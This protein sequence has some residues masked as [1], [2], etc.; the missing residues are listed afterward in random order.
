MRAILAHAGAVDPRLALVLALGAELRI[1]QVRRARRQDLSLEAGTFVVHGRGKK[2]GETIDLT[3]G[4]LVVV[5]EALATG[6][7]RDVEAA[8]QA[9]ALDDYRLFPQGQMPGGRSGA[10]VATVARHADAQPLDERTLIVWFREAEALAGVESQRGR[11]FY[12][13]RRQAVDA[14]KEGGISREGLQHLGGWSDSQV[15]DR[16]YADQESKVHRAEAAQ[17]RARIRGEET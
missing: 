4:Q 13:L 9:H 6:Y 3:A 2:G 7:L 10:P 5:R 11:A 17:V 14:A 1:G 15:P 16:I 12:G 8:Y